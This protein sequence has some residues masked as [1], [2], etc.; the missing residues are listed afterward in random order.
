MAI[1]SRTL[2][3]EYDGHGFAA[4]YS[5]YANNA[6]ND[7]NN[8]PIAET[9]ATKDELNHV[10][11]SGATPT[12]SLTCTGADTFAWAGWTKSTVSIPPAIKRYLCITYRGYWEGINLIPPF[13][14]GSD[15]SPFLGNPEYS[16]LKTFTIPASTS[17]WNDLYLKNDPSIMSLWNQD[18]DF[19]IETIFHTHGMNDYSG[20]GWSRRGFSS[21][22]SP[23]LVKSSS[24]QVIVRTSGVAFA[25]FKDF[26]MTERATLM[27][28]TPVK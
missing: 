23:R 3:D 21:G 28:V 17:T 15:I 7:E 11:P 13:D 14:Y 5:K 16:N 19:T 26:N 18:K 1:I 2:I 22:G 25:T 9:Y 24:F 20:I 4:Q 6:K 8:N 10:A 27:T 12:S